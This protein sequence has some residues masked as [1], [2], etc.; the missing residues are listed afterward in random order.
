MFAPSVGSSTFNAYCAPLFPCAAAATNSAIAA[1]RS[2]CS[3]SRQGA[4]V[5]AEMTEQRKKLM[6][7]ADRCPVHQ[8]LES[9]I[10]ISTVERPA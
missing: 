8:T 10:E 7:I 4:Q 3:I 5:P 6:E 1:G 9:K 2:L